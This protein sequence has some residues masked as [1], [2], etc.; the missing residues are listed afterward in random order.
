VGSANFTPLSHGVYDEVNLYVNE[1]RFAQQ[2]QAALRMR[3]AEATPLVHRFET[4]P[5][6]LWAERAVVAYM[7]RRLRRRRKIES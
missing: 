4:R 6:A 1:T 7:S 5:A 2:L 3:A